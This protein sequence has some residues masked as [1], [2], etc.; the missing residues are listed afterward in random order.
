MWLPQGFF[1][2]HRQSFEGFCMLLGQFCHRIFM[3][4][5]EPCMFDSPRYVVQ[6]GEMEY[7]TKT[8]GSSFASSRRPCLQL[9][10]ALFVAG[11]RSAWARSSPRRLCGPLGDTGATSPADRLHPLASSSQAVADVELLVATFGERRTLCGDREGAHDPVELLQV[12]RLSI[13]D[14][15]RA[16]QQAVHA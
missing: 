5:I 15:F 12:G 14:H 6:S 2:L 11:R 10:E 8:S 7:H 16:F 9:L 3:S 13:L 4:P 1:E